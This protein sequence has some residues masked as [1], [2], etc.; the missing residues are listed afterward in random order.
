MPVCD[1]LWTRVN[2]LTAPPIHHRT[3]A[4]A[5]R[6]AERFTGGGRSAIVL[7]FAAFYDPDARWELPA[8]GGQFSED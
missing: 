5:E 1:G 7:R 6:A 4:D 8:S 2:A 3:V